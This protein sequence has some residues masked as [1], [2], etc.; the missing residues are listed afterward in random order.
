MSPA[1]WTGHRPWN[2]VCSLDLQFNLY[3][4]RPG[5]IISDP[6]IHFKNHFFYLGVCGGKET[7][8]MCLH[9]YRGAWK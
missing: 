4:L 6:L 9:A 8:V 1:N 2:A 3:S 7:V 5:L